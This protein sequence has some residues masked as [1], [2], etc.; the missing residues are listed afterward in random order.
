MYGKAAPPSFW[1]P[2][3]KQSSRSADVMAY[4]AM[5]IPDSLDGELRNSGRGRR[6]GTKS[7]GAA[8][9]SGEPWTGAAAVPFYGEGARVDGLF[10]SRR[11]AVSRGGKHPSHAIRRG[12][13]RFPAGSHE[14]PHRSGEFPDWAEGP[15]AAGAALVWGS[16]ISKPLSGNRHDLRGR[17]PKPEIRVRSGAKGGSFGHPCTVSR[18]R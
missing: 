5:R 1:L 6:C 13:P 9:L 3:L 4:G 7:T 18:R 11:S 17:R 12:R 14:P 2:L 10:L 15:M 16:R 8:A